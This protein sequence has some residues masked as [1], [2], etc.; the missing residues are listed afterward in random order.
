MQAPTRRVACGRAWALTLATMVATALAADAPADFS[1]RLDALWTFDQP[2]ESEAHFRAE[3]ARHPPGSREALEATTQIARTYSLRRRFAEADAALAGVA[4]RLDAAPARV[5][6]RYLLERG[7]TRNSAGEKAAA[8]ALFTDALAASERDT[9]P[10]ADFYR[11][12]ALHM[13][14]IAAPAPERLQWNLRALA[15]AA[16]SADPRARGWAAPLENNIGWAYFAAGDAKTALG[17]WQRAVPLREAA[18]DARTIRIAKW[19]VA[20]GHRALGALDEAE[21]IQRALAAEIELAGA[22]DGYVYEELAEI[23]VARGDLEAAAPWAAKA[24]ALLK[25]DRG[26]TPARLA[27]L[28]RVARGIAP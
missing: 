21:A 24:H 10:G 2:A 27:R 28:D 15:A 3:L 13:L 4:P 26:V 6:V 7:R 12:D 1:E 14:G 25:D 23:A 22:P 11:V 8:V 18:G 5:R 20:R 17:H 19:T 9:L 16:A